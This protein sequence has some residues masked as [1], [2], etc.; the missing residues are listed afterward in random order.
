VGFLRRL[1]I[2]IK[3]PVA[4]AIL[5]MLACGGVAGAAYF[6]VR[7]LAADVAAERLEGAARMLADLLG[8]SFRTRTQLLQR[9]ADDPRLRQYFVDRTPEAAAAAGQV[10]EKLTPANGRW[11]IRVTDVGGATLLEAGERQDWGPAEAT[12]ATLSRP[13]GSFSVD[14][15]RESVYYELFVALRTPVGDP[16]G[17]LIERRWLGRS[18]PALELLQGMVGPQAELLIGNAAGDVWTD[19]TRPVNPV[20]VALVNSLVT[21]SPAG[22]PLSLRGVAVPESPWV[23]AAGLPTSEVA[24]P[25]RAFLRDAILITL[26]IVAV[27]ML[28]AFWS[29]RR[30]TGPLTRVTE[31]AEAI[32]AGDSQGSGPKRG[33][34]IVRLA[35][36][37]EAMSQRV[38]SSHRELAMMVDELEDRV[39]ARTA[40]LEAANSE[41]EAF[42]YSVSHDLRAPVRAV[43]GFAKILLEDHHAE[44]SP[45]ARRCV[46]VVVRRTNQMGQLIDDLLAFSRV[47]RQSM[48]RHNV[49]LTQLARAV[50][51]ELRASEPDRQVDVTIESLPCIEGEPTLLR[52]AIANLV[53]NAL[54]YTRPRDGARI[55]IGAYPSPGEH[56]IFVR[57]NGVGFDM[58]Y[59]DR[60]FGVFQR[61][62]RPDEF[63]G[64][65]VGLAIVQRIVQRHGGRVWADATVGAGATFYLA[66]PSV[67]E[68]A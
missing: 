49:D 13:S 19:F 25:V 47:G 43:A 18:T 65:G 67:K 24:E 44:L 40:A 51:E 6:E 57:D 1:S 48:G 39:H 5:L 56:V 59:S 53:Q 22:V 8:P 42:S 62:H 26:L 64:T 46:E 31:A 35:S 10:L 63:E 11:A 30:L 20:P 27:G 12:R 58:A 17:H 54:K 60:L 41:L 50:V 9:T 15:G 66:L 61:L 68:A 34:E 21:A 3:L 36:S 29:S 14:A 16:L 45:D 55:D 32:A 33:D 7:L 23:V 28:A 2:A 4:I 38:E 37:F 52:Q